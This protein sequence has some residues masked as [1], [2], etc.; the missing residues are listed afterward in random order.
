MAGKKEAKEEDSYLKDI[1][2]ISGQGGL[3]RFVSQGRNGIIV[4]SIETGKR[5]QTFTTMKV[6]ALEDIVIFSEEED[7]K[8]EEVFSRIHKY[9]NG[10]EAI[11]HKSDPGD[12]KD[13][14]SAV[15]PEYDRDRVY[16]SDI[17]KVLNWYNLLHKYK[18]L[19][20]EEPE[21]EV[22]KTSE[23]DQS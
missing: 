13:Y 16:V 22:K 10:A 11:S 2:A 18:M 3:F 8:L 14:F 6:N 12:L 23:K 7:I 9:E 20:S 19:K 21:K 1:M 5:M 15:I 17:R 4:E